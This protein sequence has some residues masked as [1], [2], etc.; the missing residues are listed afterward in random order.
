[1]LSDYQMALLGMRAVN[2]LFFVFSLVL[3]KR[4]GDETIGRPYG[5]WVFLLLAVV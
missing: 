4:V 1:M 3:A 5:L 2:G